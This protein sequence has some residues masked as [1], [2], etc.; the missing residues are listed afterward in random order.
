VIALG[1]ELGHRRVLAEIEDAA[2]GDYVE[3]GV[4]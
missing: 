1:R 4:L 2:G 3:P